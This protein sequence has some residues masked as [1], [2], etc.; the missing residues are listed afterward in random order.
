MN[1]GIVESEA[2]AWREI[3]MGNRPASAM[4][5]P[6]TGMSSNERVSRGNGHQDAASPLAATTT[7]AIAE[8]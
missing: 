7:A 8:I 5:A 6:S 1:M 3:S 2:G 4:K